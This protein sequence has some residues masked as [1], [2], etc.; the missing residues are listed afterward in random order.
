VNRAGTLPEKEEDKED[1]ES[2]NIVAKEEPID[3]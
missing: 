3:A 2:S 1:R